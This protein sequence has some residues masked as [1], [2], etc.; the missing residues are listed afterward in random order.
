MNASIINI[1]NE[2]LSGL[3]VNTNASYIAQQLDELGIDVKRIDTMADETDE[4]NRVLDH[5]LLHSD[6][7]IITGGL[8]PTNDD[9]T[10]ITLANRFGMKLVFHEPSF[11]NIQKLFANRGVDVSETNR[12]QAFLPDGCTPLL[13]TQG[14]APGMWFEVENK[15]V[16]SIPGVPFEMKSLMQTEIVPRLREKVQS[17]VI[18]RKLYYTTGIA[19]SNLQDMLRDWEVIL[20]ENVQLAYL[21]EPGIVKLRLSVFSMTMNEAEKILSSIE[22]SLKNLLGTLIYGEDDDVMEAVV[23]KLLSSQN[24]SLSVAESCTGGYVSHLITSIQGSSVYF[25]GGVVSY[26]NEVKSEVL[27][28]NSGL[29]DKHGAVSKEVVTVMA[30]NVRILMKTDYAIATSGIAGPDGGT[31]EKP[32]G[33]VWIAIATPNGVEAKRFNFGEHRMRNIRRASLAAL[34]ELRLVLLEQVKQ[35]NR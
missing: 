8:G 16:V 18:L 30:Q 12:Q 26:A 32:V 17:R 24:K 25:K 13:N 19:E 3:I 1:G 34:N 22:T 5:H 14:T 31:A 20:P 6:L 29:I 10:K 15:I 23:G 28:I 2:L 11:M 21:P 27:N 7:I 33:T 9:I 4:I 35:V